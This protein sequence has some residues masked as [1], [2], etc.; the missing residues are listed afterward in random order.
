MKKNIFLKK[1]FFIMKVINVLKKALLFLMLSVIVYSP[2]MI[3]C[4][5]VI[6]NRFYFI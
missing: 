5:V 6:D 4:E 2:N 1:I 3:F